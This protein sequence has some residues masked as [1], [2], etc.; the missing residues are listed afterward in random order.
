GRE[1]NHDHSLDWHQMDDPWHGGVARWV[2]DLNRVYQNEPSLHELD[3][4]PGGFDWVD[5]SD[6]HSGIISFL[7]KGSSPN[8]A[9][10]VA[11]NF[12][13]VTRCG[14]RVGVPFPGRWHEV[15]NSDAEVYGGSGQGNQGGMEAEEQPWHGRPYSLML[16]AVP[17]G[18]VVFKGRAAEGAL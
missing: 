11:C 9:L 16:T 13:P 17:L 18:V 14:Y 6:G 3:C 15:L 8:E 10:L 7:R 1:W 4:K 2:A 5:C 12:T